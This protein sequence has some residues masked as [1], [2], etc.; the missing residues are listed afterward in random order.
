MTF[1]EMRLPGV[2]VVETDMFPDERGVFHRLWTPEGF[3]AEGLETTIAQAGISTNRRRGTLRGLHLQVPPFAQAKTLYAT[4][5]AVF[6]VVVDLRAESPTYLQW[7]GVELTADNGRALYVP[8]GLAHGYQ[9]LT[10]DA[11]VM[12]F[13]S[14]PYAPAAERGVRWNDPAFAIVWPIDPPSIVHPRD[15]GFPD[16]APARALPRS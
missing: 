14:A 10:D 9:T 6:D 1:T 16:F 2:F 12:Y 15:A 8:P 11:A 3:A 5:G 13:V 4:R 7:V